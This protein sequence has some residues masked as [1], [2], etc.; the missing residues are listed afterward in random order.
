MNIVRHSASR[1]RYLQMAA[2]RPRAGRQPPTSWMRTEPGWVDKGTRSYA[3][4]ILQAQVPCMYS[5]ACR[6]HQVAHIPIVLPVGFFNRVADTFC[7][8]IR[9]PIVDHSFFPLRPL[10]FHAFLA[11]NAYRIVHSTKKNHSLKV[12]SPCVSGQC[13]TTAAQ[14]FAFSFSFPKE[15]TFNPSGSFDPNERSVKGSS[16]RSRRVKPCGDWFSASAPGS[17]PLMDLVRLSWLAS[18][19]WP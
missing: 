1:F 7:T 11:S 2:T 5:S 17:L 18:R 4:C 16:C 9:I 15:V 10:A 14:G 3:R 13:H 12:I 6:W 8:T 19:P